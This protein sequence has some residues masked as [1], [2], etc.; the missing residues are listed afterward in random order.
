MKCRYCKTKIS[1]ES[2]ILYFGKCYHCYY[3]I[4][5]NTLEHKKWVE[6]HNRQM[7]DSNKYWEDKTEP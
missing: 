1:F 7:K 3:R 2:W 6:E 4:E 5:D